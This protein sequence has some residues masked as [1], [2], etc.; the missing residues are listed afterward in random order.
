MLKITKNEEKVEN[1]RNQHVESTEND[2]RIFKQRLRTV[3]EYGYIEKEL[4]LESVIIT[5]N[6]LLEL[7]KDL[8]NEKESDQYYCICI[9]FKQ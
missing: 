4:Y 1:W 8:Q 3:L 2:G 7:Y 9:A 6:G 5:A